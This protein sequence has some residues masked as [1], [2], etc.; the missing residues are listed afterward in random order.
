MGTSEELAAK[1]LDDCVLAV[2]L[3]KYEL[4]VT[5][6]QNHHPKPLVER[7]ASLK[8]QSCPSRNG[9]VPYYEVPYYWQCEVQP[10]PTTNAPPSCSASRCH[11]Q[12][13]K[14]P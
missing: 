10:Y 2:A 8:V 11:W 6:S 5:G 4:S 13:V 14:Q 9:E 3:L 12:S 1:L 7:L